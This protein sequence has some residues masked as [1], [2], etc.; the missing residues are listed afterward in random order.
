VTA[1]IRGTIAV[2]LALVLFDAPARA[3]RASPSDASA[4][5]AASGTAADD[6]R[7]SART[8][9]AI[10]EVHFA[11]GT[12]VA[13]TARGDDA[14]RTRTA[15]RAAFREIR[16]LESVL[17]AWDPDS[18]TSRVNRDAGGPPHEVAAELVTVVDAALRLTHETDGAFSILVGPIVDAWRAADMD[19]ADAPQPVALARA[20]TLARPQDLLRDGRSLA[21]RRAG[22]RLD[23]DG[24]AKG[25]AADRAL[26]ILRAHGVRAAIVNLGGSS[27][28]AYGDA[29]DGAP[30][31][32]VEIP[33]PATGAAV[34]RPPTLTAAAPSRSAAAHAITVRLVDEALSAS[35]SSTAE[36]DD[37]PG[38]RRVI[39]DP[40]NGQ[41]VTRD[42]TAVVLHRSATDAEAWSKA[43]LVGGWHH[44][45][46]LA[47]HDVQA[48]LLEGPHLPLCTAR[49]HNRAGDCKDLRSAAASSLRSR[50]G[51]ER[52]GG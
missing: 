6:R 3:H 13:I 15:I 32:P 8:D 9:D 14:E 7:D 20:T 44:A 31:W 47:Q 41:R 38:R 51:E 34:A 11:M 43:L 10:V 52:V 36:G 27:M 26:A 37:G 5:P 1:A 22:M 18:E 33:L 42:A 12:P 16:R 24:I 21:L 48:I 45:A 40:R 17:T 30:G 4:Q 2:A 50:H 25:V 28:A 29:G 39:V 23:L 46:L 49:F 19:A 35:S